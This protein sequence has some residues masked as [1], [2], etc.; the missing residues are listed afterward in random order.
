M[1]EQISGIDS[2]VAGDIAQGVEL[3]VGG[4]E[5]IGL[6]DEAQPELAELRLELIDREI[7]AEA[8]NGLQLI[9]RAAGMAERAAGHHRNDDAR[10]RGQWRDNEAGLIADAAGGVLVDLHAG[11]IGEIHGFA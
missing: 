8:G 1:D 6:A 11:D 4:R 10:R 2:T 5:L 9:Q 7:G 3:A